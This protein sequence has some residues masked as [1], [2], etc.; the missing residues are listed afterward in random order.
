MA[1]NLSAGLIS[2]GGSFKDYSAVLLKEEYMAEAKDTAAQTS[3]MDRYK[4][5][6]D[7]IDTSITNNRDKLS[8]AIID[9][10]LDS[11]LQMGKAVL[12]QAIL[13]GKALPIDSWNSI[14]KLS[15]AEA[16]ET[17]GE[18]EASEG[19]FFNAV[20]ELFSATTD[21]LSEAAK[22]LQKWL[23]SNVS[24]EDF[25]ST[26]R[27]AVYKGSPDELEKALGNAEEKIQG[28]IDWYKS[29]KKGDVGRTNAEMEARVNTVKDAEEKRKGA[30]NTEVR[31]DKED[32]D[33]ET[34][35]GGIDPEPPLGSETVNGIPQ[36]GIGSEAT[37]RSLF[38][39][40]GGPI[41]EPAGKTTVRDFVIGKPKVEIEVSS[42]EIEER[43]ST[44]LSNVFSAIK[45]VESNVMGYNAVADTTDGDRGLTTS[46]VKE[47]LDK[48][49]NTAV[50]VG[51]FK[52]KEFMK[53]TAEKWFGMTEDQLK[54]QMFTPQFQDA[55]LIAGIYDAGLQQFVDDKI[56]VD[57]FQKRLANIWRGLPPTRETKEGDIV[58]EF[59]N[60][61]RM[62]GEEFRSLLLQFNTMTKG[63]IQEGTESLQ[64][65]MGQ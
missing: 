32:T 45:G 50:G 53:P 64:G 26:P 11:E 27:G 14:L 20:G 61:A 36:T 56:S 37:R 52:Y 25:Q 22:K 13:E 30:L 1:I 47:V 62:S 60:K 21:D 39:D 59:E 57:V 54:E 35:G 9:S 24:N 31:Y 10:K 49:G 8:G 40:V 18:K 6:L 2:A 65:I 44:I 38:E 46:T 58:D 28:I 5:V 43:K 12:V 19:G 41:G 63:L 55:L 23:K 3:L 7:T 33:E 4:T 29:L 16:E 48:H 15:G 34:L 51:Q 42:P 17:A